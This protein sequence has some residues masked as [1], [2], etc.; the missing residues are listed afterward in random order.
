[1]KFKLEFDCNS[2]AF[3]RDLGD[4][5]FALEVYEVSNILH[6][7]AGRV[8]F[9]DTDGTILDCLGNTVGSWELA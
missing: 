3:V 5:E 7:V 1:M 4:N 9:G 6:G 8:A 2:A